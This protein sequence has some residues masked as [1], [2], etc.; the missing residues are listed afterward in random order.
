[1]NVHRPES[2][3][4]SRKSSR[5]ILVAAL[6]AVAMMMALAVTAHGHAVGVAVS[7]GPIATSPDGVTSEWIVVYKNSTGLALG[8]GHG[9][10]KTRHSYRIIPGLAKGLTAQELEQ[11]KRDPSVAYITPDAV[12]RLLRSTTAS[13]TFD[14][15]L[16]TTGDSAPIIPYGIDLVNATQVWP[17]TMGSGVKI[18]DIDTGID[19]TH[20]D[21]PLIV[22]ST[23]FT[24]LPVQDNGSNATIGHG[25]YTAGIMAAPG[26]AGGVEGVAPA[27]GLLIAQVFDSAGNATDSDIIAAIDWAI[28]NGAQVINMS[29]GGSDDDPALDQA[30]ESAVAAGAVVVAAAGNDGDNTPSYPAAYPSVIAV[31]AV[32]MSEEAADFS[33]YGSDIAL[34]APGVGVLSTVPVDYGWLVTANWNGGEHQAS[35]IEGSGNGSLT[36]KA[37][38]CNLGQSALDFPAGVAGNIAHIRRG[39]NTF[40]EKVDNAIAAGAAGVIISNNVPDSTAGSSGDTFG[41]ALGETVSQV[42]VVVSQANGNDLQ[43]NDGAT[44]TITNTNPADYAVYDGTSMAAPH[45]S[46]VAALLIAARHGQITPAQVKSAMESSAY[47]LGGSGWNEFYGYGLVD[48]KAALGQVIPV[49]QAA[50]VSPKTVQA[51]GSLTVSVTLSTSTGV[52]SVTANGVSLSGSGSV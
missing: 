40:E 32:D 49:E 4:R 36:A 52:S 12:R 1:M 35:P 28:Q 16:S 43:A 5:A 25:T 38:Y 27:A 46:G 11:V 34:S 24:D 9:I 13:G 8:A 39:A 2:S 21:L 45:V 3:A 42:V 22:A 20:P 47:S 30:C 10:G 23:T 29:L 50:T 37:V 26:N 31:A 14:T 41:A 51:G 48:A 6:L 7:A 19:L 44:A 15:I 17:Y 33:N 18:A